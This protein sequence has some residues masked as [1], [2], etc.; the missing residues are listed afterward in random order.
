[1]KTDELLTFL[2][3]FQHGLK[4]TKDDFRTLVEKVSRKPSGPPYF[5][6]IHFSKNEILFKSFSQSDVVSGWRHDGGASPEIHAVFKTHPV[7]K[8]HVHIQQACITSMMFMVDFLVFK[9][10][11]WESFPLGI[12]PVVIGLFFLFGIQLMFIGILGEYIG[13]IHAYLQRRP[14]VVEKERINF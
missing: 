9:L 10:L 4:R 2:R 12:A 3:G 11:F 7:A 5:I 1:M 8:Q 13:S 14:V 6:R